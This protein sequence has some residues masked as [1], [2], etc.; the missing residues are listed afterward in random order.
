MDILISVDNIKCGGC[1]NSIRQRMAKI[2]HVLTVEV[3]IKGENVLI[4]A[5]QDIR[6]QAIEALSAMGYPEKGTQEGL[7][8]F[9]S[10][11]TSF[12]S[13]ALGKISDKN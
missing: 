1:A 7:Q 6:A 5:E 2:P 13:C 12:V 11:A 9:G 4:T 8:A 3:D 10:K